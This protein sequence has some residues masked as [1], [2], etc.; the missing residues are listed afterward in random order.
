MPIIYH[1]A[2]LDINR[3][4]KWFLAEDPATEIDWL[5]IVLYRPSL[6]LEKDIDTQ[7]IILYTGTI[8]KGE[9]EYVFL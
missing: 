6:L 8:L 5:S 7:S 1:M 3:D 4:D 2:T 9:R